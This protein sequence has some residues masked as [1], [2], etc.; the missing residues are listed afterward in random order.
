MHLLNPEC[1]RMHLRDSEGVRMHPLDSEGV[2]MHPPDREGVRMHSLEKESKSIRLNQE[3]S[4]CI[5]INRKE[6]V[7][8][9]L[10]KSRKFK[11]LKRMAWTQNASI[12]CSQYACECKSLC[13]KVNGTETECIQVNDKMHSRNGM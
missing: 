2:K 4:G 7:C 1:V 9:D 8:M 13:I 5:C 10:V 3:L 11:K 6:S 12:V